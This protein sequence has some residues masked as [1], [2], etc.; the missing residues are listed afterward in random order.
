V[1]D[2]KWNL[3]SSH[4]PLTENEVKILR[5][6]L[7]NTTFFN[8]ISADIIQHMQYRAKGEHEINALQV[9]CNKIGMLACTYQYCFKNKSKFN[10]KS[11]LQSTSNPSINQSFEKI[12][13]ELKKLGD[14]AIEDMRY[15]LKGNK[16]SRQSKLNTI[17][18]IGNTMISMIL[19]GIVF[20][21]ISE[22][23]LHKFTLLWDQ[24]QGFQFGMF[25]SYATN[26][27]IDFSNYKTILK[28][29][30]YNQ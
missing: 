5:N 14:N 7:T 25:Y 22:D 8:I 1:N 28:E 19:I 30:E 17:E 26:N 29:F 12:S 13:E 23:T 2:I 10:I 4:Y 16:S 9:I 21:K 11:E 6:I 24:Y 3:E 27:K 15:T 20:E 18:L